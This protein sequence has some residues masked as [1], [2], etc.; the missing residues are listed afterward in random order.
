ME[1]IF[2]SMACSSSP[3]VLYVEDNFFNQQLANQIFSSLGYSLTIVNNG[4]EAIS[5]L[6]GESFDFILMDINMP[7][8][9]GYETTLFIRRKI[10]L[11]I[12]IIAL[13]SFDDD[14]A[15]KMCKLC[16]MNNHL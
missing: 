6:L 8:L 15:I 7:G 5:L 3:K 4:R 13:S 9:S 16:G 1:S 11:D 12:P 10:G 2:T 14:D